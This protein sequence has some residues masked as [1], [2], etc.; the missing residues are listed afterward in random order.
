MAFVK[1]LPNFLEAKKRPFGGHRN[2]VHKEHN[3]N[4][5]L[6]QGH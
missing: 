6:I 2:T 3:N 4:I 5:T 1:G